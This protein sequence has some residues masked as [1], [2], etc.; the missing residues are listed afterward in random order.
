MVPVSN[1]EPRF[2]FAPMQRGVVVWLDKEGW[3]EP[4]VSRWGLVP[5][6]SKDGKM[7]GMTI[8]AMAETV[9]TKPTYRSAFK[10]RPCLVVA[11]GFY[12]WK[13]L[14]QKDKQPYFITR[15]GSRPFAFAGFWEWWRAKDAPKQ[16]PGLETFTIIT[17]ETNSLCAEVHDRMPVMLVPEDFSKWLGTPEDRAALMKPFDSNDMEM[18]PVGAAVGNVKNQGPELIERVAA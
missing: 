6:W 15:K 3:R 17:C 18:W 5:S 2:N 14:G 10:A 7:P 13:K 8:I 9:A 4:V 11:E 12:E 16:E 1:M